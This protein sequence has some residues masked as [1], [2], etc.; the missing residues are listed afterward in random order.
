[1]AD[2]ADKHQWVV[3]ATVEVDVQYARRAV[4]RGSIRLPERARID[5]LETYCA[6]CRRPWDDVFDE[7]CEAADSNEHLRGGPIGVRKKRKQFRHHHDCSRYG[8]EH[9]CEALG[10]GPLPRAIPDQNIPLVG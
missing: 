4:L 7:P 8:C 1:M 6:V 10:C 9:D 3:A 5:A 2:A